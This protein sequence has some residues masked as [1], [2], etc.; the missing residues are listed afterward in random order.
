MPGWINHRQ[1]RRPDP[2]GSQGHPKAGGLP[3]K[4]CQSMLIAEDLLLLLLDDRSGKPLLEAT[5]LQLALA[6]GVLLEL[7][8]A[9]RVDAADPGEQVKKGRLVVRDRT[10]TGDDVLDDALALLDEREGKKPESVLGKLGKGLRE[11]LLARLA[12]RGILREEK[13][14]ALG[15][16][17][18]TRW[19][20]ID[21]QH[22]ESVRSGLH[23]ALVVGQQPDQRTGALIALLAAVDA[24]P[25]V[26][27]ARDKN[28]VKDRAR[29]IAEGTWA[30][31]SVRK[32]VQAANAA[33]MAA[34]IAGTTAAGSGAASS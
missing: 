20:A 8:I 33:L 34:V 27:D 25:K 16:F 32:A 7:A 3:W 29:L 24:V 30:A 10:S 14:K 28:A 9:E 1:E 13:G 21:A 5:R 26:M 15:I 2:V 6:G 17:P 22:E 11:R 12:A 23:A 18:T 4:G 31:D 19:P